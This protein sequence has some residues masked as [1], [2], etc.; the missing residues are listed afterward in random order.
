M[1]PSG[2]FSL[3]ERLMKDKLFKLR[4]DLNKKEKKFLSIAGLVVILVFWGILFASKLFPE[5][6]FPSPIKVVTSL[7]E[8]FKEDGLI[9]NII[10]SLKLNFLGYIAALAISLPIGFAMGL[11]PIFRE[12][13]SKVVDSGRFLPLTA[14]TGLFIAWFGIYD[15]MKISFL[16]FG[17]TLYLIPVVVNRVKELDQVYV[18]TAHTLGATTWHKIRYVF[19]PGVMSKVFDDVRVVV[20]IS[21]TYIIIAEMLNKTE[22]IGALIAT[23]ARQSRID[24]VFMLLFIII[25]IGIAQDKLFK[26]IDGWLYPHKY[27][28]EL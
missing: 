28:S 2:P 19:I 24:K 17:I 10:Y 1:G 18:D 5:A 22:G 20:A 25:L 15:F 13:F 12:M 14:V 16:A 26:L 6:L 8:L 27:R 4:G 7:P 23:V 11:F 21:W 3:E 9:G